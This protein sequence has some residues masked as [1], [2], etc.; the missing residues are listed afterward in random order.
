MSERMIAYDH[1]IVPQET[2]W[3]CG[4][5]ST[6]VVLNGL[7]LRVAESQLAAEIEEIENPGRGDDR[8]GT[9]YIGLIE[10]VLDRRAPQ[11]RY[12][13]VYTPTDPMNAAQKDRF[14]RDLTASIDGGFG[15]VVNIVAPPNNPPRAVKGSVAPPY[16]R[17]STTL[18]YA[19]LMGYDDSPNARA[20]WFADSAAF[21]GITGFWCPFDGP[22]S[23]CSLIT[24]KGYCYAAAPTPAPAPAPDA[25]AP[26]A[27]AVLSQAMGAAVSRDRYAALTPALSDCLRHCDATTADRIAM[28]CAQIG[29]ESGGLQWMEEL[30]DGSAYE[31]RADLGNLQSG[32][33]RKFK[34]RGPIQITGR[35]NYQQLS[36]WAYR[37]GLVPTTTFFIDSPE[38]LSSD[39][40]GFLGVTWYWTVAR[41]QINTLADLGDLE[42]VTRAIN[43]G[44]NGIADRRDRYTRAKSLGDQLLTLTAT[45][46]GNDMASVPQDQWDRV[47]RELTQRLPSR[48]IYRTPGEGVI[49][50]AAGMLLN[51]DAMQHAELVERLARL[52]D[53]DALTRVA[54]TAAGQGAVSD[55][56][57]I[58]QAAAVLAD[59]ERTNPTVLS[60]FLKGA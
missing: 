53:R 26:D 21:G 16:P 57:A 55:P 51:V 32:D 6:Q 35:S 10:Q 60:E 5:A 39:R 46:T 9:D 13:T 59:I 22:G 15:V 29:H 49:D 17:S 23:I 30:A 58:A 1:S 20:V 37:Q 45:T 2:G 18:H 43:G 38:Q 27:V 11:A 48:S 52:G 3:W 31:G 24:P 36:V 12:T 4:P 54:R 41:P 7:G 19:S 50:T 44:L 42:G 34:G 25:V 28:W 8:D 47:Y 56:Q 14:W 40:Y 33:G